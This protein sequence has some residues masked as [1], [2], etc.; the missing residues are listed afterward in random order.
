MATT[1]KVTARQLATYIVRDGAR[2]HYDATTRAILGDGLYVY[3]VPLKSGG[4][5]FDVIVTEE[6][7][8]EVWSI[9]NGK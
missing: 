5:W 7:R 4:Y 6:Q 2:L 3:R 9:I 8:A 1:R